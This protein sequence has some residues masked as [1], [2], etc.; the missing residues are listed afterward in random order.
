MWDM[1]LSV[2]NAI[3]A[4]ILA[5]LAIAG[6]SQRNP[7]PESPLNPQLYQSWELQPGDTVAGYSVTGGLGDLSIAVKGNAVYAPYEGQLQPQK[8]GCVFFSSTDVPN[9]LLRL[10]GLRRP[11]YGPRRTGEIL[12]TADTLQFAVLNKRPDGLWAF[13][14]PSTQ[15]LEQM[16]PAQ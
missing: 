4:A 6:C 16:L 8:P 13:V 2:F 11:R 7:P 9:Y 14:E 3:L 5:L 1:D 15:I 10:C 12:G